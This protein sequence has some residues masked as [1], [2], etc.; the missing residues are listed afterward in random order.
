MIANQFSQLV[1]SS[2]DIGVVSIQQTKHFRKH[3]RHIITTALKQLFA[4]LHAM[5]TIQ[6]PLTNLV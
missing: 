6:A 5:T 4:R 2:R 1:F 3:V